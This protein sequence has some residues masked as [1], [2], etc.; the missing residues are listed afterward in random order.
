MTTGH[1]SNEIGQAP[2]NPPSANAEGRSRRG[3]ILRVIVLFAALLLVAGVI[4][5]RKTLAYTI[6]GFDMPA[7]QGNYEVG[8]VSWDVLSPDRMEVFSE[9]PADRREIRVDVYYPAKDS[10]VRQPGVYLEPQIAEGV[11]GL[12]AFVVSKIRPNW[13]PGAEP[14]RSGAPYPVLLFSPG[15]EGPPVFYT[16]LLEQ[17]ASQG[18][19]IV[20]LWHPYTTSRTLFSDGRIVESK[21]EAN[22]AM[23]EGDEASREAAKQRV[24]AV[25]AEDVRM[26]LDE[27]AKRNEDEEYGGL[28]DLQRV[29]VFGHSFGGQNAAAAMTIDPRIRAG[30]NMDGTAVYQPILDKGVT[31]AFALLYDTFEPPPIEYLQSKGKSTREWWIEDWSPRNCPNALRQNASQFYAFQIDGLSHEG[32]CTDLSLLQEVFPFAITQD[33]V[34]TVDGRRLLDMLSTLVQGFFD[35][36]LSGKEVPF[37]QQPQEAFPELHTGIKGYPDPSLAPPN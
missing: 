25:W 35:K 34:G 7:L 12:P 14:D 29:G 37:L 28:F 23:W 30:L 11:T 27:V 22:G 2:D 31:G 21:Y 19:V 32:F 33:M 10:S 8:R 9:D 4:I 16:S 26:A 13:R 6:W 1:T 3:R 18:Y 36:H 20:A 24:S 5:V 17:L 15:V